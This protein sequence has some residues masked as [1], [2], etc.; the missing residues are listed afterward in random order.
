MALFAQ[1]VRKF[2][3]AFREIQREAVSDMVPAKREVAGLEPL[4][5]T[6]AH[7]QEVAAADS[8]IQRKFGQ[9]AVTAEDDAFA[10]ALARAA[11]TGAVPA[12]ISVK[13]SQ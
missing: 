3:K 1:A 6:L 12:S 11:A 8:S 2:E 10:E 13:V 7:A 4:A 5:E 9:Y